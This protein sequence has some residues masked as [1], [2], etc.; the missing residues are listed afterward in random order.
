MSLRGGSEWRGGD[1]G[2]I[3]PKSG[4]SKALTTSPRYRNAGTMNGFLAI[5]SI[6][7]EIM[8]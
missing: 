7:R 1:G 5:C 3:G 8:S 2:L 6:C 4:T